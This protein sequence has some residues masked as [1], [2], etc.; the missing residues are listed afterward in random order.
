[1][2]LEQKFIVIVMSSFTSFTSV[3]LKGHK[4]P[5]SCLELEKDDFK[6]LISGSEDK[7][8]RLWDVQVNRPTKCIHGCFSNAIES[9][10][11]GKDKNIIYVACSSSVFTFDMRYDGILTKEPMASIQLNNNIDEV[12]SVA[13]N[14]KGD[15]LGIA[16]E[17]GVINLVPI[18]KNGEFC[19]NA[20]ATKHKRLSRVHNNIV[21]SINFKPKNPRELLSGGFDYIGCVWDIDRGR[22]KASTTF[23][24]LE[25]ED[26]D[27][28]EVED[29]PVVA[30]SA[31]AGEGSIHGDGADTESS[32]EG[33]DSALAPIPAAVSAPQKQ[34]QRPLRRK[35]KAPSAQL[36][37][38]PFV[39]SL[40]YMYDGR[41]VAAALGDG[42]VYTFAVIAANM[43]LQFICSLVLFFLF[44]ACV[45]T[46]CFLQVRILNAKDL[47]HK[48]AVSQHNCMISAFYSDNYSFF[49][50]GTLIGELQ[51]KYSSII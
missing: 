49:T 31:E 11:F 50:G 39:M 6:L 17:S 23:Q 10:K 9:V 45:S 37:N 26:E 32:K 20:G 36:V 2:E 7:T 16:M 21:S 14:A 41:C 35:Q 28:E 47:T 3:K 4:A 29:V 51:F 18:G 43:L 44:N 40:N 34:A 19:P 46:A 15:T 1:V 24:H 33:G 12:S 25:E 42:S 48:I 38:P 5:V 13:L 8:V 22:P 27:E 30:N